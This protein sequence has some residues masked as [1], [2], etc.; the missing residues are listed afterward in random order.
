MDINRYRLPGFEKRFSRQP[1][2]RA[3]LVILETRGKSKSFLEE[4]F[5]EMKELSAAAA[6]RIEGQLQ[7]HLP[8]PSPSHFVR[9]GKLAE[10]RDLAKAAHANVLVFNS[11]L[12]PSQAGNIEAFTQIPVLDRTGLILD[13]FGRRARSKK[14]N[15]RSNLLSSI[16]H[17]HG[18]VDLEV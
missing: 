17:C 7:A 11:D 15:F 2:N 12:T 6:I 8:H 4:S 1:R 13:I 9:E 5:Q 10:I 18:L 16:M 14:E 3:F